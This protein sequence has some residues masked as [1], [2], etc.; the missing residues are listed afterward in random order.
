MSDDIIKKGVIREYLKALGL[1]LFVIIIILIRLPASL[2]YIL[3]AVLWVIFFIWVFKGKNYSRLFVSKGSP[4]IFRGAKKVKVKPDQE[5]KGEYVLTRTLQDGTIETDK[6]IKQFTIYLGEG[7]FGTKVASGGEKI[8]M[9]E[10]D[11][12]EKERQ[13]RYLEQL[14]GERKEQK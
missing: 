8:D 12:A 4:Y 11:V 3:F 7:W 14:K 13:R 9:K 10:V 6:G 5:H 1:I 2:G